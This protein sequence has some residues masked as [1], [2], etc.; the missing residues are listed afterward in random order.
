MMNAQRCSPR[1]RRGFIGWTCSESASPPQRLGV[2]LAFNPMLALP[3]M[4][5][6]GLAGLTFR[7]I[8]KP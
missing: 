2:I 3:G 5:A 7:S 6:G 1:P 4:V 8:G